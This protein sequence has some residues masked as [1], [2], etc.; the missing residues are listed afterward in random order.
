MKSNF[1]KLFII[2]YLLF[3][4]LNCSFQ[5][6]FFNEMNKNKKGKNLIIISPLSIFQILSLTANGARGKTQLEMIEALRNT[7]IETLNSIN[8][9]ILE[10][11]K[12]FKSVEIANA[13]MSK[14]TPLQEFMKISEKYCA[15]FERLISANQVNNWCNEKTHGKITKII[16]HFLLQFG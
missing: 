7:N 14:F 4:S 8:Y 16:P 15:P 3:T 9:K 1:L 13:V 2:N 12:G 6:S 5:V 10:T 11:F